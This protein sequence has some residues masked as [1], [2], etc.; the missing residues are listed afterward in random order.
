MLPLLQRYYTQQALIADLEQTHCS[1]VKLLAVS[2]TRPACDVAVLYSAGQR[3]FGENYLQDALKKQQVLA[4]LDISWHFIGPIQS[5]KTRDIARYFSWV[6]SVDRLKIATRLNQQRPAYLPPLNICLQVNVDEEETKSGF[7]LDELL[8]VIEPILSL[9]NI[10]LRG[11][12]AI[13]KVDKPIAEQHASFR[14]MAQAKKEIEQTFD[15]SLDTL[16]MGMSGDLQVAVAEG[17]TMVR[18]G[19]AIF[20]ERLK[21]TV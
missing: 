8:D 12:M 10:R 20:G 11:L 9:E 4:H 14:K 17:A 7:Y 13:P 2:K 15:I 19:T 3:D 16:S 21:N 1:S 5:N 6:H 18:V